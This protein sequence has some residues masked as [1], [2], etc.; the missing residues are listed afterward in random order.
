MPAN[1]CGDLGLSQPTYD[2]YLSYLE[3]AF[4]VFTLPNYSG[5]ETSV[6]H[7]GRKLYFIDCAVRNAALHRGLAPLAD[8]IEL[9]ALMENLIAA[10]VRSPCIPEC[11]CSTGGRATTRSTSSSIT[12]L[13][14]WHSRLHRRQITHAA[15]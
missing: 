9:G 6:E 5:S 4:L 13:G 8:P 1:I 12:R 10:S 14:R 11:A 15:G 3:R 7:R 2:R